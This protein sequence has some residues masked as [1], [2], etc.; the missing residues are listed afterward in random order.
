MRGRGAI[1][2]GEVAYTFEGPLRE[3]TVRARPNRF[4]VI[5][6]DGTRCHLHDPGRLRE[7]IYPGNR[8]LVRP[9]RGLRTSCSVTAAWSNGRWVVV[10]SRVHNRVAS[11]FLPQGARPEVRVGDSRLDFKYDDTYVEVKGCTLVVDGVALF[12]DAPTE[13]GRRHAEELARLRGEGHGALMMFLIMRDDALCLSPNWSTDPAFSLQFASM[14]KAG[15]A[16][17]AH[18]FRLEGNNLVYVGDVPLC[19]GALSGR[20]AAPPAAPWP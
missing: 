12:P 20:P 4:L 10:D 18:K 11:L 3:A 14:V 1:R 13:R 17:E 8:V 9:T 5:L 7:L 6:D 15:V 19:E 16:V 2:P